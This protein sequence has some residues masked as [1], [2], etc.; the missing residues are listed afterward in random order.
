MY[1]IYGLRLGP[2]FVLQLVAG[3]NF[4]LWL[5]VEKMHAFAVLYDKYLRPYHRS[6][7]N[8]MTTVKCTNPKTE[9]KVKSL[10]YISWKYKSTY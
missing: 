2:N 7:T 4:Y 8:F 5:M 3:K 6:D 10:K 9:I 1:R